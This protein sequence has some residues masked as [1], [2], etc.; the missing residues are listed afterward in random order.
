LVSPLAWKDVLVA[1][2]KPSVSVGVFPAF[3]GN[4]KY[5]SDRVWGRGTFVGK[6]E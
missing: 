6:L 5:I 4:G 2:S 3:I 1:G